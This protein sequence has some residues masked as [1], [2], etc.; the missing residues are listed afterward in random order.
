M[1]EAAKVTDIIIASEATLAMDTNMISGSKRT[2]DPDMALSR[3]MDNRHQ[4]GIRLQ[5]R[6]LPPARPWWHHG[7]WVSIWLHVAEQLTDIH[8]AFDSNVGNTGHICCS[9]STDPRVAL[10]SAEPIDINMASD[11]S[12]FHVSKYGF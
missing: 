9:R 2:K 1:P 11:S 6:L 8:M 7:P 12:I 5:H 4:H 10:L 3:S